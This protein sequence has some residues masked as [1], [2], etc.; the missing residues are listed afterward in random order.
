MSVDERR[1]PDHAEPAGRKFGFVRSVVGVL[2]LVGIQALS[3]VFFS[4]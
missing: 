1:G 2:G 4:V 3:G